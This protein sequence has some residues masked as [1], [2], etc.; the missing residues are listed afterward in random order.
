MSA[1]Q[2]FLSAIYSGVEGII[3]WLTV[4]VVRKIKGRIMRISRIYSYEEV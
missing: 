1:K 4:S 3:G 2:S